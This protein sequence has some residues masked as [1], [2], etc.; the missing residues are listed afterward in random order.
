MKPLNYNA[1]EIGEE[2]FRRW[3]ERRSADEGLL[4]ERLL[5]KI[6]PILT[7]TGFKRVS[8]PVEGGRVQVGEVRFERSNPDATV[9]YVSIG[10]GV[11][12]RSRF[13]IV[14]AVLYQREDGEWLSKRTG[15]LVWR[16]RI[17]AKYKVWKPRKLSLNRA[18]AIEDVV[19]RAA[20]AFPQLMRFLEGET[21]GPNVMDH[22]FFTGK[23]AENAAAD[24]APE[25]P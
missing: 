5:D 23:P 2:R 10:F 13:N 6:V 21:P 4:V 20:Q 9:T 16:K 19:G 22:G 8:T 25:K 24:S 7:G 15:W 17:E 14:A 18:L 1:S 12:R 11:T 3:L